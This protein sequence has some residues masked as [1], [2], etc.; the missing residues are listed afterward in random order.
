MDAFTSF[1]PHYLHV[2][3]QLFTE[4]EKD[5]LQTILDAGRH[6]HIK[7]GE[8]LFRQ[9]DAQDIMF[10]VLT[11]RL[12]AV[13]QDE[14]GTHILGDIGEGEPVGEFA[15][16][17]NEPRTASVLAI[18]KTTLL[19]IN[20]AEYLHLVSQNP[21][22]A[23]TLTNFLIKR[24]RRNLLEQSVS[25]MPK[26]IA[27]INLQPSY[28]IHPWTD[29]IEKTFEEKG[30]STNVYDHT[31]HPD[32][33]YDFIFE[34]LEQHIGFNVLVCSEDSMEWSRQCLIYADLVVVATNFNA[35]PGLYA[36]EKELE[37]Y[38][39]HILNKKIY[40]V[41]L[42]GENAE[43]PTHTERWLKPRN[44]GLHIHIR[45][46]HAGDVRRL[47][48]I[49]SNQAVGLVLGGGGSKGYAHVGGV[50]ALLN[51]GVEIDFLGGTSAGALY[52]IAM[53]HADFQF[54]KI[55]AL[56]EES[57][58]AKLT[59]NDYTVP[60][61]SMLSGKKMVNFLKKM[62]G[63]SHL[64]DIWINSYC[65]SANFSTS[66]TMVHDKGLTSKMVQASIAIPGVFPPVVIDKHLHVDGGVVEN[67][68]IDQMYRY[69]VKHII[70]ISLSPL[71]TRLVDYIVAPTARQLFW[72]KFSRKKQYKIPGLVSLIVNSLTLNS[73]Q[74][75]EVAKQKVSLYVELD[76]K[77]VGLMDD[78]KW[79]ETIEKGYTQVEEFLKDLPAKEKF[80]QKKDAF[81]KEPAESLVPDSI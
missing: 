3:G 31:S 56:S 72:D 14:K 59:S 33:N 18:R 22:F 43:L 68:P 19:E 47:C 26:N 8:Y 53:T 66:G 13:L 65:V 51:A 16:F 25:E 23:S 79:R 41:F 55:D 12:R 58:L 7:T 78:T 28:D 61:V 15:I 57:A 29:D 80:W 60:F 37:L 48:R 42:H 49:L 36:I 9:G 35:D 44:A 54:E 39:Q 11:G 6:V 69:P 64:E 20:K 27:L 4:L 21:S 63:S 17:T 32:K 1:N 81:V 67:L 62:F 46:H 74:R 73:R 30:M 2:L 10:I 24:L 77:G 45:Q 5:A 75:Q 70:A 38:T 52:G 71:N 50:R 40:I 76:L 34:T